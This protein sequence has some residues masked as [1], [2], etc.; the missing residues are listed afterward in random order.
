MSE[1]EY[2][3]E[4]G[5]DDLPEN[6]SP[7][8]PPPSPDNHPTDNPAIKVKNWMNPVPTIYSD[9]REWSG[10]VA[11][12]E[13][14]IYEI[15]GD[16]KWWMADLDLTWTYEHEGPHHWNTRWNIRWNHT[17]GYFQLEL[18]KWLVK[19]CPAPREV[20]ETLKGSLPPALAK[21]FEDVAEG[22]PEAEGTAQP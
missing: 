8:N 7:S 18:P 3:D 9:E 4:R 1:K 17:V 6:P 12:T 10:G 2:P 16:P 13:L 19:F 21:Y 5:S 14:R 15:P 11:E 22:N 20:L